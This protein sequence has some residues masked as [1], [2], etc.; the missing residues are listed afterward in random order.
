MSLLE[1]TATEPNSFMIIG[2]LYIY[3]RRGPSDPNGSLS[4]ACDER[5]RNSRLN[6]SKL[7][8]IFGVHLPDWRNHVRRL[9]E[10]LASQ[11][12]L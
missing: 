8:S 4:I 12:G 9:I 3:P 11:G 10:E 7:T 6:G 1:L 5:P 2:A